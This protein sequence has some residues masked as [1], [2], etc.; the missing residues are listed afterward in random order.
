MLPPPA[1][2]TGLTIEDSR[3]LISDG[4]G[5]RDTNRSSTPLLTPLPP[6]S[7]DRDISPGWLLTVLM[8]A[9]GD[10]AIRRGPW[11]YIPELATE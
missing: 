1:Q 6:K 3:L 7:P 10:L 5:H 9:S 2:A 11:E 8:S 4:E